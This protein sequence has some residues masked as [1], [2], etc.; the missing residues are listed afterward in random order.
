MSSSNKCF[1]IG[2]AGGTCAG[3]KA[4]CAQI[5]HQ[6]QTHFPSENAIFVL[7]A[8]NFYKPLSES[9]LTACTNSEYN[10]DT[11]SNSLTL[12]V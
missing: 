10:F 6:L 4:L 5:K 8:E 7:H 12:F 1:I 3:K 9:E 11:P 2:V